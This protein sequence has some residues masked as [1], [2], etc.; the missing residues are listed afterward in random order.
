MMALYAPA[1]PTSRTAPLSALR[2]VNMTTYGSL[3]SKNGP[4]LAPSSQQIP[5]I[6]FIVF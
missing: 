3:A 4:A 6:V 5:F 2:T 1:F